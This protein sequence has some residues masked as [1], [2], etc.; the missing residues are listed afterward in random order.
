MEP[1]NEKDLLHVLVRL[2]DVRREAVVHGGDPW[3]FRQAMIMV[4]AMDTETALE[5]GIEASTLAKFDELAE[6][7]AQ[8]FLE[9]IPEEVKARGL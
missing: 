3:A 6:E 7:K 8:E 4:M 9:S 1:V 2:R 5:R